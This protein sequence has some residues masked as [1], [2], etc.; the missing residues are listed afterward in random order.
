LQSVIP[1]IGNEGYALEFRTPLLPKKH[2][3]YSS[4]GLSGRAH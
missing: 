2:Q 1:V 3:N 4:R